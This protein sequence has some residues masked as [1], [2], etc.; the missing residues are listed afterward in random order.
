[1]LMVLPIE[2]AL[3]YVQPLYLRAEGGRIHQLERVVVAYQNQVVMERRLEAGLARLFGGAGAEPPPTRV[4]AA[5]EAPAA[6][7]STTAPAPNAASAE[8]LRRAQQHYDRAMEA[9]RAGN[10]AQYGSEIAQ[11]GAVLKQLQGS[12]N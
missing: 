5:G 2:D 10:W 4:A 1:A 11:L 7:V 8:L 12:K 6:P 9:Q 3:I